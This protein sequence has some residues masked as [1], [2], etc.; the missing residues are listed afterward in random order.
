MSLK[1]G[2]GRLTVDGSGKTLN[3]LVIVPADA[4]VTGAY[5]RKGWPPTLAV[6][7]DALSEA[8][9]SHGEECQIEGGPKVRAT[10]L[11]DVRAV[12]YRTYVVKSE[13]TETAAQAGDARKKAFHRCVERA[14][15]ARLIGVRVLPDNRRLIWLAVTEYGEVI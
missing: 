10:D 9:L 1:A 5:N 12:F 14:Q 11:E 2:S 8:I 3:S 7:R 4:A 13:K 6:F 15:A